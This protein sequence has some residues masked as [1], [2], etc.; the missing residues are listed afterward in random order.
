MKWIKKNKIFEITDKLRKPWMNS[1]ATV[2]LLDKH[3]E[4]C[5]IYFSTRDIDN[6]SHIGCLEVEINDVLKVKKIFNEPILTP[7]ELGT[8]D[9]NGVMPSCIVNHN[10]KK[11]LYYIGWNKG[12]NV[13]FHT[14]IGLAVSEDNGKS[15]KKKSKGPI[16]D[17]DYVEPHFC[18]NPYVIIENEIWRMWYISIVKWIKENDETFPYYHIKYAESNDGINWNRKNTVCIDFKD[19]QEW[20]ISRPCIIKENNIYKMWYSFSG[21]LPYRIGYAESNDGINWNRKDNL[22]GI[23]VSKSGW[24][25]ESIEYPFVFVHNRQKFMLYCGN[26]FGK[27]GFGYAVLEQD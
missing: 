27:T 17:R 16:L 20:A 24:D 15:F 7:G 14:S 23:S 19:D 3:N 18:S 9:D 12:S 21:N 1:F 22:V 26:G 4:N 11:Y 6:R 10:D 25:S 5:K 8:F 13:R 2:P